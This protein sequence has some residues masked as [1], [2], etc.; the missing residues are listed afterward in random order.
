MSTTT[1]SE[2]SSPYLA[3]VGTV[4]S[5]MGAHSSWSTSGFG[6]HWSSLSPVD[7]IQSRRLPEPPP[8]ANARPG[9]SLQQ[10][11]DG[12]VYTPESEYSDIEKY[13]EVLPPRKLS[14][15]AKEATDMDGYLRPTFGH[16]T[17]A[18]S[19]VELRRQRG[20]DHAGSV[21][22]VASYQA[23]MDL[24]PTS[25]SMSSLEAPDSFGLVPL[26]TPSSSGE[27]QPLEMQQQL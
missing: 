18:D 4:S 11:D 25:A 20:G 14:Q 8:L 7:E 19:D 16:V 10:A 22:P 13:A 12:Y 5:R 21:I 23:P 2:F 17:H 6:S 3:S 9:P 24:L 27:W 15:A 26:I 1:R